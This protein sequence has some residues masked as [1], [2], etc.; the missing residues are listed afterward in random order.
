MPLSSAQL[1]NLACQTCNTPGFTAQ[2]GQFLN[3]ILAD[4]ADT[5]NL[6]LCRGTFNFNFVVDNGS[7]NGSGPYSLPVDYKRA[8]R[9]GV[10]YVYNGVPYSLTSVDYT[11]YKLLVQQA[12]IANFPVNYATDISGL[13]QEPP[14]AP[15]LYVWPPASFAFPVTVIYRRL[16]PDIMTPETSSEVPWF[17]NQ[18]Y[19]QAE[20]NARLCA[21][22]GD[23]RVTQFNGEAEAR[24]G[25]F[26]ALA[27]DSQGRAATITLDARQFRPPFSLL[28]NTKLIGW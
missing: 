16:L 23:E 15:L 25:K 24:L 26:M 4:L 21:L 19:L 27:N 8:E 7:G 28:P 10:F 12:G 18:G 13:G 6:D 9:D 11:Q 3:A 22:A 17:P 1:V 14:T 5:Q 2:A 20:L